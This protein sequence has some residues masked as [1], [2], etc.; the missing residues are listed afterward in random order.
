MDR[1]NGG[2][3]YGSSISSYDPGHSVELK[4]GKSNISNINIKEDNQDKQDNIL[5]NSSIKKVM[6]KNRE[7][8][9]EV[10][11]LQTENEKLKKENIKYKKIAEKYKSM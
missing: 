2:N 7:L 3:L 11:K 1:F 4:G 10:V 9:K 5:M 6:Q 8:H